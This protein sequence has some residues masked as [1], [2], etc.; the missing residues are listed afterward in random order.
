M[1]KS[2]KHQDALG[3]FDN[4]RAPWQTETGEDAEIVPSTLARLIY[5]LR[6]D[7]AKLADAA[8]DLK[9]DVAAKQAEVD[10]AKQEAA[11]AA[12]GDAQKTIDKL[13]KERDDARAERDGL[14]KEKEVAEA[15]K[16]VVGEF[17]AKHPKAAKYVKGETTEELEASL[18]EV[19]EDWGIDLENLDGEPGEED[20]ED[21]DTDLDRVARTAP[22]G[23]SLTNGL[24]RAN[25][26]GGEQEVDYEKV[27]GSIISGGR[28][29]G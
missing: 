21:G 18:K 13:T 14:V 15:R 20:D 7:K 25:G 9:A 23:P 1:A 2:T 27:A 28:V 26:K 24:D 22:R 8:E 11:D 29:F 10:T 12:G 6:L 17:E 16:E 4:F 19:A 3:S 5:N